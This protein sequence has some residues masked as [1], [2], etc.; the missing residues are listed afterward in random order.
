[1]SVGDGVVSTHAIKT[2]RNAQASFTVFINLPLC[3]VALTVLLISLRGVTV[4]E[5]STVSLGQLKSFDFIGL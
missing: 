5:V 1:M 3:L 4:L 2:R